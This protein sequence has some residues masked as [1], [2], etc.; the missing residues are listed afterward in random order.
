MFGLLHIYALAVGVLA[1]ALAPSAT[2]AQN[3]SAPFVL[4][5]DASRTPVT[6]IV[7]VHETMPVTP[8]TFDFAYPR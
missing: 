4:L 6:G 5:V 8:G 2:L 7:H 1:I 3:A